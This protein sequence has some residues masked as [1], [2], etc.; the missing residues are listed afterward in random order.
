VPETFWFTLRELF[1]ALLNACRI[2]N[3]CAISH[4]TSPAGSRAHGDTAH[5]D[6]VERFA[7]GGFDA[8]ERDLRVW[9]LVAGHAR[10]HGAAGAAGMQLGG[11]DG[12]QESG[13]VEVAK[14]PARTGA[15]GPVAH[16]SHEREDLR[17][18]RL[19]VLI[20]KL[21]R[22]NRDGLKA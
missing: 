4:R 20:G 13:R 2:K 17:C 9:P 10:R 21:H 19:S 8:V 14:T 1:Q 11:T 7:S 6:M 15:G 22:E 18:V 16:K 12:W 3:F 5:G